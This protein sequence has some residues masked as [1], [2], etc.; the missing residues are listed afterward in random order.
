MDGSLHLVVPSRAEELGR[1][2]G[3]ADIAAEGHRQKKQGQLIA[4]AHGGQGVFSHEAARHKAVC[5]I[6]ELLKDH[7]AEQGQTKPQQHPGGLALRQIMHHHASPPFFDFPPYCSTEPGGG[8][9]ALCAKN[10]EGK[11]GIHLV[12]DTI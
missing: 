10:R 9:M 1:H 2:H 5:Q 6:V 7:A 11:R 4:V 12:K 3:A 8:A